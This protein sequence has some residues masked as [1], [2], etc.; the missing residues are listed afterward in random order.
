MTTKTSPRKFRNGGHAP[1]R[2]FGAWMG[3]T[4]EGGGLWVATYKDQKFSIEKRRAEPGCP[5][6][7]WYFGP[8]SPDGTYCGPSAEDAAEMAMVEADKTWMVV[9]H[10]HNDRV[11]RRGYETSEAA[12]AVRTELEKSDPYFKDHGNL[13][14]VRG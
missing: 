7:W 4:S 10:D 11:V 13:W 6:G 9:D 8:G 14:I 2:Y 12:A 5:A 1:T 3:F